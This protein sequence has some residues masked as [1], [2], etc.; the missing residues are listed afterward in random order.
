MF[1][2]HLLGSVDENGQLSAVYGLRSENARSRGGC[3]EILMQQMAL[4]NPLF[5][6]CGHGM[7]VV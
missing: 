7:H 1:A 4:R 2:A 6:E 5:V 3:F